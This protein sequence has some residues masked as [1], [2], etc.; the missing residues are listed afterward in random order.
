M[1]ATPFL[2][3]FSGGGYAKET[4]NLHVVKEHNAVDGG[5]VEILEIN[6][7]QG[8]TRPRD[9]AHWVLP[10]GCYGRRCID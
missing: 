3:Y 6:C 7:S 2:E 9:I 4:R 5:H 1:R 10:E 8:S